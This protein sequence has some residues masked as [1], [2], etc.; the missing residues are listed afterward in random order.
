MI[1]KGA[2]YGL[3]NLLLPNKSI[4]QK[5][6]TREAKS[7]KTPASVSLKLLKATAVGTLL[8]LVTQTQSPGPAEAVR[9]VRP[10]PGHFLASI[11]N[12]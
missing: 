4:L 12:N 9:P 6:D 2:Q 1:T 7:V 11:M 3:A 10:L 5:F 8:Y